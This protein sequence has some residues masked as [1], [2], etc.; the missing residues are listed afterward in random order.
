MRSSWFKWLLILAVLLVSSGGHAHAVADHA[1]AKAQSCA[2][3]QHQDHVPSRPDSH[4]ECCCTCLACPAGLVAPA[5][6]A[7]PHPVAYGVTLAPER[8]SPL[9]S[10][11][12][13]PELD[14]PRPGTPS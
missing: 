11:S 8:A 7:A 9:A 3:H 4:P 10:R 13:S 6:A 14:P 2:L 1:V 5:E 12:L